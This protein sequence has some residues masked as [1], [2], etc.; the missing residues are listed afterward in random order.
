MNEGISKIILEQHVVEDYLVH[1]YIAPKQYEDNQLSNITSNLNII[2]DSKIVWQYWGTGL[3]TAPD[4]VQACVRSVKRQIPNDYKYVF[5]DD[6]NIHEYV[7]IP[8]WLSQKKDQIGYTH[9]SDILRLFLLENY[10]GV[11]IDATILLTSGIPQDIL[12]SPLFVYY[13]DVPPKNTSE[14]MEF[15]PSYFSWHP[16]FCVKMCNSFISSCAPH[17]PL[18]REL[19]KLLIEYWKNEQD[20]RHYFIFQ[21]LFKN[22]ISLDKFKNVHWDMKDDLLLHQTLLHLKEDYDSSRWER[23]CQVS[24]AHKLTYLSHT[25]K[26]SLFNWIIKHY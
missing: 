19:L 1:N 2:T 20:V 22:I 17:H 25:D 6:T 7:S 9:F 16:D 24:F 14:W 11:W 3:D 8:L 4:I 13:R 12:Q 26:D 21:I 10:G 15:N 18:I 23:L 5:L